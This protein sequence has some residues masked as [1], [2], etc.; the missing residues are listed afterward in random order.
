M[1]IG[2]AVV[3]RLNSEGTP[4]RLAPKIG[5]TKGTDKRNDNKAIPALLDNRD[6]IPTATGAMTGD[7]LERKESEKQIYGTSLPL[8]S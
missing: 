8:P 5:S 4:R 3:M 6:G 2:L 7:Q 1:S